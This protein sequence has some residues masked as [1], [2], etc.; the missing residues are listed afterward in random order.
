MLRFL[1]AGESH[2]KSL[3]TIIE[4]MPAG[5]SLSAGNINLQLARRQRGYGRGGRMKIETDKV[6]ILSGVR[7]GK[8]L[9]T[10]IALQIENKD[11]EN[12][13]KVMNV[14]E[15]PDKPEVIRIEK[16]GRLRQVEG[17]VSCPRPGHA[18]LGGILKYNHQDVRNVLERASARETATRVAVGA[19]ARTLLESFG[20]GI[21]S[22]VQEI[23]CV[24]SSF[25]ATDC[26][27]CYEEVEASLLRCGDKKAETKMVAEIDHAKEMGDS[28]GGVF[29]VIM[30]QLPPGLGSF[31]H[32]DRRLDG[33]LA[34][35]LMSIQAIKGV[36]IGD[37]FASARIKGS[38][39]HDGIAYEPQKGYFHLSNR[40]GG[41]EGG[42]SNGEMI[43]LRCAM[44]PIPTLYH[45][46]ETVDI[47]TKE[48]KMASVERSDVCAVPAAAVV[49]EAMVAFV[50]ARAFLDQFSGDCI[51]DIKQQFTHY[52][53][54]IRGEH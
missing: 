29:E 4:G 51:G 38:E 24:K 3:V 22:H 13:Q 18:D 49:G 30:T 25:N 32:W 1:N 17:T 50:M 19:V 15:I 8:T 45:P 20:I 28:L 46:L 23:G 41:L 39:V 40:A 31:A 11:W 10:P 7:D 35:A 44:K 5:L 53:E 52:S 26:C 27:N 14:E 9:G 37:G 21:Y 47:K 34:Q 36:E 12:W 43:V 33:L 48:K 54:R 6:E 16:D 42:M 2:G